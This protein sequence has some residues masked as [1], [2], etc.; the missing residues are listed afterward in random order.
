MTHAVKNE[1]DMYNFIV[2]VFYNFFLLA[3]TKKKINSSPKRD[4]L[5]QDV[6]SL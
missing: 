5:P 4:P 6:S 1:K 2:L 3:I